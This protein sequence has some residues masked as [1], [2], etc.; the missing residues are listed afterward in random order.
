MTLSDDRSRM[1]RKGLHNI[2]LVYYHFLQAYP[3]E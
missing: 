2:Y 3:K 1:D